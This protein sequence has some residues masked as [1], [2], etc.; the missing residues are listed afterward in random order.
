MQALTL[1][2]AQAAAVESLDYDGP[3][4]TAQIMA[5][6]TERN[7]LLVRL[8]REYRATWFYQMGKTGYECSFC[9][10]MFEY[11]SH[12]HQH[13]GHEECCPLPDVMAVLL[14]TQE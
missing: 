9:R 4:D 14:G 6:L 12:M 3:A 10:A 2:E 5:L 13:E 7:E 1:T 11:A 8:I